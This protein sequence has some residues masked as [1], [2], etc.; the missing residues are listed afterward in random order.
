MDRRVFLGALTGSLLAAPFAAQAQQV[1]KVPRIGV[2]VPA[3][4]QSP[5]EPNVYCS[6]GCP[7]CPI[8][9]K[10]CFAV[11]PPQISA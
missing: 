7:A 10:G 1:G 2:L 11:A 9:R 5:T 6:V 8:I 3:E 4:P